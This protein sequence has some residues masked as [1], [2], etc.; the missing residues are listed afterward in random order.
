MPID[1]LA[2][3]A[4][5]P[6]Q[7]GWKNATVEDMRVVH[8][9]LVELDTT[10]REM[11]SILTEAGRKE[12]Q[13]LAD[14]IASEAAYRYDKGEFE[15]KGLITKGYKQFW[16]S[17]REPQEILRVLGP[18][19]YDVL[20]RSYIAAERSR[21]ELLATF[22]RRFMA[23]LDNMPKAIKDARHDPLEDLEGVEMP[24]DFDRKYT[25]NRLWMYM[26]AWNMG[27]KS[28]RERLLGG[29]QWEEE[30]VLKWLRRNMKP[31]EWQWV[32]SIW[33]MLD[34]ELWPRV[35]QTYREAKGIAPKKIEALPIETP[36]GEVS[37]GYFAAKYDP[38]LSRV[39]VEQ[40]RSQ[41]ERTYHR[42]SGAISVAR[43]MTKE[44]AKKYSDVISL[45]WGV[46][47]AHV[48][49]TI[50]YVGFDRF[51]RNA[52]ALMRNDTFSRTVRHRM[53]QEFIEELSDPDH[54]W[55]GRVASS[56]G[57]PAR[58]LEIILGLLRDAFMRKVIAW[59]IPIAA[60][61][62]INPAGVT[63]LGKVDPK[64]V[65]TSYARVF[66]TL[67]FG[68]TRRNALKKSHEMRRL[69]ENWQRKLS[70]QMREISGKGGR[71]EKVLRANQA[72]NETGF[73]F[74]DW[75]N[76]F[77]ST[78]LWDAKYRE[79][80]DKTGDEKK[81]IAAADDVIQSAIPH[82]FDPGRRAGILANKALRPFL[83]FFGYFNK[84]YN[85]IATRLDPVINDWR[86]AEG[87]KDYAK[88]MPRATFAAGAVF[89]YL[90]TQQLIAELI[91]GHGPEDDEEWEDWAIRKMIAAPFTMVPMG[92]MGGET[93]GSEA[94]P[95]ITGRE[96]KARVFSSRASPAAVPLQQAY[97][98]VKSYQK[99]DRP[100]DQKFW[101]I[102]SLLGFVSVLGANA[103]IRAGRYI[104]GGKDRSPAGAATGVIHGEGKHKAKNVF[105]VAEEV[106]R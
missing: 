25:T 68:K 85:M 77:V 49:S 101:D 86:K 95:I 40:D 30:A 2:Q 26:V 33:K 91:M 98:A 35:A 97:H 87:V 29:Y 52:G 34:E 22:G 51:V 20:W 31:E 58:G 14:T 69:A 11:T 57:T 54:G 36:Y 104:T 82:Y 92:G 81:A 5:N 47:P 83:I 93:L 16:S 62:V 66:G 15:T 17:L 43:S 102:I 38:V 75:S 72:L 32:Q 19:A 80:F 67:S 27:S 48:L 103:P 105:T 1:R 84:S 76:R 42:R 100:L 3:I 96:S 71:V 70:A 8:D 12:I 18:T 55:L 88:L 94:T 106:L 61:D 6:P 13:D 45:D 50:H 79:V 65:A 56:G 73:V 60:A 10:A 99:E 21:D 44:R 89:A 7:D 28:N 59:N 63:A 24:A 37:G 64:Y 78:I 41:L 39:G 9:A 53:G 23:A 46:F 4:K 90:A 74:F